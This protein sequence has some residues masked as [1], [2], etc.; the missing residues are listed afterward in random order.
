MDQARRR[1]ERLNRELA[2]G[3]T[4]TK[5]LNELNASADAASWEARHQVLTNN[6]WELLE[7]RFVGGTT[8][9]IAALT[10]LDAYLIYRD[11]KMSQYVMAPYI[12]GDEQGFF[13][14][15]EKPSLTSPK[16]HKAYLSGSAAGQWMELTPSDF[17]TLKEEAEALWGTTDWKGDFV[18][19]LL[20]RELPVVGAQDAVQ[21]Q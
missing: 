4:E 20:N 5:V 9:A 19:G 12:L 11:T 17:R 7:R 2:P 21:L 15:E 8:K 14:L 18:P 10:L 6:R 16:Y 13:T 1:V 3:E